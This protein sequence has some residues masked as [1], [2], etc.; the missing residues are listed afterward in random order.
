MKTSSSNVVIPRYVFSDD[1]I[2]VAENLLTND[3]ITTADEYQTKGVLLD[4]NHIYETLKALARFYAI[5]MMMASDDQTKSKLNE[6]KSRSELN[7]AN[8]S[9]V[10]CGGGADNSKEV[11][12]ELFQQYNSIGI[13]SGKLKE[14]E[15]K[16]RI[17]NVMENLRGENC[18]LV[19][20]VSHG[21][22]NPSNIVFKYG[23][24][25]NEPVSCKFI[26]FSHSCFQSNGFDILYF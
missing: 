22:L 8:H 9:I 26:N 7:S 3:T 13:K 6:I 20:L 19:V 4:D 18:A 25:N 23:D 11:V 1:D 15:F 12:D 5:S 10:I 14:I 16:S 17:N 24:G 2:L 21:Y